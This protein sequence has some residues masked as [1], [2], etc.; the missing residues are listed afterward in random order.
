MYWRTR[1]IVVVERGVL[2]QPILVARP[3]GDQ[4]AEDVVTNPAGTLRGSDA[5]LLH[6]TSDGLGDLDVDVVTRIRI[7]ARRFPVDEG[8]EDALAF[9]MV[10][11]RRPVFQQDPIAGCPGQVALNIV[12]G[13]EDQGIEPGQA[14]L[15]TADWALSSEERAF[16][17]RLASKTGLSS[18]W[19]LPSWERVQVPESP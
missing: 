8:G 4:V 2:G 15:P 16:A 7:D 10:I 6:R 18:E 9:G 5:C 13:Q 12:G 19:S 1:Q 14:I 17:L 3:I 11:V